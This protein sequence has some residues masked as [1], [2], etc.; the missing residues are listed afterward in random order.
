MY[1]VHFTQVSTHLEN[2][3]Q[4]VNVEHQ[5]IRVEHPDHGRNVVFMSEYDYQGLVETLHLLSNPANA[6][7]LL[8]AVVR[9]P[10]EAKSW[11]EVKPELDL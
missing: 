5:P 8:S 11:D 6:E 7:K 10:A 3:M 9:G 1:T 4:Q 2:F